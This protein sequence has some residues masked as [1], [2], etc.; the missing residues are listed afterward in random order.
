MKDSKLVC[1]VLSLT[2]LC[3]NLCVLRRPFVFRSSA[4]FIVSKIGGTF[5]H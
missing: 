2:C 3:V 4:Y 5:L 1:V